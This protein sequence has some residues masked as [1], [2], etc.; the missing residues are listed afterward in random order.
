[1]SKIQYARSGHWLNLS[2]AAQPGGLVRLRITT[3]PQNVPT[4]RVFRMECRNRE[5]L[6]A[7][8]E[9]GQ[10]LRCSSCKKCHFPAAGRLRS[11]LALIH[12]AVDENMNRCHAQYELTSFIIDKPRRP[13][14]MRLGSSI[15][16]LHQILPCGIE[17]RLWDLT[18]SLA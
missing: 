3:T 5:N 7:Q 6:D 13:H 4:S 14:E 8:S 2:T 18:R 1:M 11:F 15:S 12:A 10:L 16:Y 9:L 17:I